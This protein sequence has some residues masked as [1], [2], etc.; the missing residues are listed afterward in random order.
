MFIVPDLLPT[1]PVT[2]VYF[3][4]LTSIQ[5]AIAVFSRVAPILWR[6]TPQ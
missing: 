1:A 6:P 3:Y 5:A 4:T 2:L